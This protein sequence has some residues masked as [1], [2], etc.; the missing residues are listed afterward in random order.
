MCTPPSRELLTPFLPPPF[1]LF[2]APPP[3]SCCER[4]VLGHAVAAAAA[5]AEREVVREAAAVHSELWT[6]EEDEALSMAVHKDAKEGEEEMWGLQAAAAKKAAAAIIAAEEAEAAGGVVVVRGG[7]G[8]RRGGRRG[9]GRG[10]GERDG[11]T[12]VVPSRS[13]KDRWRNI[14]FEVNVSCEHVPGGRVR[15]KKECHRRWREQRKAA[16]AAVTAAKE[17][18]AAKTAI[19]VERVL[20]AEA[21]KVG[22]EAMWACAEDCC[23]NEQSGLAKRCQ[24]CGKDRPARPP[25][26]LAFPRDA[27][28]YD[29]SLVSFATATT[30]IDQLEAVPVGGRYN[31]P[32]TRA[33]HIAAPYHSNGS[34]RTES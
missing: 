19:I 17:T 20:A 33:P 2:S 9:G 11:S 15:S 27:R 7:Q 16:A 21:D 3:I 34:E 23:G 26:V 4:P 1:F 32:C 10:G 29:G 22:D 8:G 30:A 5:A 12:L 28:L 31:R 18:E 25:P 6:L 24:R 13:K 14:A